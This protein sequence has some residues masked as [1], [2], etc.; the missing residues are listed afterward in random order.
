MN[1][2]PKLSYPAYS[3]DHPLLLCVWLEFKARAG[4]TL[5]HALK[6]HTRI[7]THDPNREQRALGMISMAIL[8]LCSLQPRVLLPKSL[9]ILP[10][11]S[12]PRPF[13][14]ELCE[15]G[16]PLDNRTSPLVTS[17]CLEQHTA[18]GASLRPECLHTHTRTQYLQYISSNMTLFSIKMIVIAEIQKSLKCTLSF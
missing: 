13:L 9:T 8:S 12:L 14:S 15:V 16:F 11:W 5:H 10:P 1:T 2:L 18:T 7:Y 4:F 17:G 3:S 6:P